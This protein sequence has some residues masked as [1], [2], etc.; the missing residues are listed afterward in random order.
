M[1]LKTLGVIV[2]TALALFT[3]FYWLTDSGRRAAATASAAEEQLAYAEEV[4]GPPT[5]ANPVTANCAQCHGPD[6]KGGGPDAPVQGPNLH[7]AAR[8]AAPGDQLQLRAPGRSATA[9]SSSPAI[10]NSPMPAW[11]TEVGRAAHRPADRRGDRARHRAGRR[12]ARPASQAPVAEHGR[13]RRAGLHQ[14]RLRRVP[15]RRPGGRARPVPE[16]PGHRH[17]A[18]H[19]PSR[20]AVRARP[21]EDRLRRRSR[22]RSWRSGSATR[23]RTT[24]A[25]RRRTCRPIDAGDSSPT[26]R[27]RRSSPSCSRGNE[28]L[29]TVAHYRP[30]RRR[31]SPA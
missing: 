10:V 1:R 15:R 29:M 22:A 28:R 21:D 12:R 27:S 11:S 4:F 3:M 6:G 20:P 7:G 19:R 26:T 25:A 16:H 5:A 2:V 14:R 24:T 17:G 23:A 13:G 31:G 18:R 9:A 8:G 30:R